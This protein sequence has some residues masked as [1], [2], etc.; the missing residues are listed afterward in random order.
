MLFD[1]LKDIIVN[2]KGTIPLFEYVPFLINRW[3][4]F[5]SPQVCSVLNE[6]VNKNY[7]LDKEMHY[8]FLL[9]A[10]PKQKFMSKIT[11][12]K[13]VKNIDIEKDTN[14]NM[15]AKG[16]EQSTREVKMLLEFSKQMS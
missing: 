7:F 11:Y 6:T 9:T 14:I 5:I 2:K 16:R 8:K 13:K 1:Y 3:L 10:F 12:I 4:S 15:L